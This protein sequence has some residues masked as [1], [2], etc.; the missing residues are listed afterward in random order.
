LG[1]THGGES[2]LAGGVLFPEAGRKLEGDVLALLPVLG[3]DVETRDAV[4]EIRLEGQD[5][6]VDGYAVIDTP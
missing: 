1:D 4:I 5:D 2:A 6:V 3:D